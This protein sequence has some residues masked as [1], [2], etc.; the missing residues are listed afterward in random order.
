[1]TEEELI[2]GV[3]KTIPN[4]TYSERELA[5]AFTMFRNGYEY[6]IEKMKSKNKI[7][8]IT[9]RGFEFDDIGYSSL[10]PINFFLT[11]E[12]RD[13]AFNELVEKKLKWFETCKADDIKYNGSQTHGD[14]EYQI[15]VNDGSTLEL[16]MGNWCY[17]WG[18]TEYDIKDYV[19]LNINQ[20]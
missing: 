2:E 10:E 15:N 8:A 5:L 3:K 7:Y 16:Y 18:K 1:M 20:E 17:E 19:K 12:K 6:A 14:E 9:H 11:E 4:D 13:N